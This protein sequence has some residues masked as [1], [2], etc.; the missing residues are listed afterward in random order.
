[1]R[2]LVNSSRCVVS[3][4]SSGGGPK[5]IVWLL[6]FASAAHAQLE[7]DPAYG[8][9]SDFRNWLTAN[10]YGYTRPDG[11]VTADEA[12]LDTATNQVELAGN[13]RLQLS[14]PPTPKQ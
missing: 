13:V 11:V 1:M 7:S 10:G 4:T 9:S 2:R 5:P 8:L 12:V 14:D 6:L 3:H